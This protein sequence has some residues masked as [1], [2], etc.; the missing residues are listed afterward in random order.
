MSQK[1]DVGGGIAKSAHTERRRKLQ[2]M[3]PAA[4]VMLRLLERAVFVAAASASNGVLPPDGAGE[5][6]AANP[7]LNDYLILVLIGADR[8]R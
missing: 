8:R 5:A 6:L 4:C 1:A 2:I 3:E 7:I